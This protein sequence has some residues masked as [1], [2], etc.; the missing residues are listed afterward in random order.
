[1]NWLKGMVFIAEVFS[2][3]T[4]FRLF[5]DCLVEGVHFTLPKPVR[6]S[7]NSEQVRPLQE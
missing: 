3:P 2:L 7:G 5:P 6:Q 1:M 4:V